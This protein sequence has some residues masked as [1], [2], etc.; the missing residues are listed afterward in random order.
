[1]RFADSRT[2]AQA[3]FY[4]IPLGLSYPSASQALQADFACQA[5]VPHSTGNPNWA[6]FC[7]HR[8]DAQINSAVA[9]ETNNSPNTAAL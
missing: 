3:A 1:M 9:A 4:T 8:L 7:D 6:E 5:F 2:K